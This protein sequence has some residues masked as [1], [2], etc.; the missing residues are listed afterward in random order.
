M[1]SRLGEREQA[2]VL[3]I[4]SELQPEERY[5]TAD[6]FATSNRRRFLRGSPVDFGLET[7]LN[8]I[9]PPVTMVVIW[10]YGVVK[11]EVRAALEER[12]RDVVRKIF[13][14]KDPVLPPESPRLSA[15]QTGTAAQQ[16]FSAL[17][18]ELMKYGVALGLAP[19]MAEILAELAVSKAREATG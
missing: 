3:E 18:A 2:M 4:V 5:L 17:R 1:S 14:I 15:P 11:G 8:L 7:E 9:T 6:Y 19:R 16:D 12:L 13:K 10:A